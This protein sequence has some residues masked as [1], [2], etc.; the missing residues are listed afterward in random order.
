MID[1]IITY[2]RFSIFLSLSVNIILH[3]IINILLFLTLAS[4]IIDVS[5]IVITNH[6]IILTSYF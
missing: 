5:I 3:Y 4:A 1:K 2:L 6:I